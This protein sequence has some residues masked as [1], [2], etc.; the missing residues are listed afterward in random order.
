M[1]IKWYCSNGLDSSN[2]EWFIGINC[3][4]HVWEERYNLDEKNSNIDKL[5]CKNWEEQNLDK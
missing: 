1:L 4:I 3:N 5:F 2:L